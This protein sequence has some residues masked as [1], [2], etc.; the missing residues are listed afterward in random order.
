M[1]VAIHQP[2]YAPWC[3]YFAKMAHCDL[4][5]FLDDVQMPNGRSY[6][7]RCRIAGPTGAAWLS[8]PVHHSRDERIL[9]VRFADPKWPQRHLRTLQ[10]RYGRAP[11]Y[12][13][14]MR[15][16]RPLYA[17]PGETLCAF[18]LRLIAT[19]RACLGLTCP[20]RCASELG[21]PGQG[22]D[23]LLALLRAVG[24]DC[25][26]SGPGGQAYQDPAKFAAAGIALEVRTY[27][28]IPYP[29]AGLEFVPGLSI[30]DPLFYLGA[31][32]RGLLRY[33]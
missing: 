18:N 17:D 14:V 28:P 30:L 23:R 16:L 10:A 29:R 26:L 7:S 6:V 13:E 11:H 3:G 25:Y 27:T 22:D 2:N 21:V 31:D 20:V 8:V 15:Q 12:A 1:R 33:G 9:T 24:A 5:I 32:A 19:I 4:F